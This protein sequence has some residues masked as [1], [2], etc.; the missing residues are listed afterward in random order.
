MAL[1]V[2]LVDV[3][4]W[5]DKDLPA[6]FL[7]GFRAVGVIADTGVHRPLQPPPLGDMSDFR[8]HYDTVIMSAGSTRRTGP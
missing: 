6:G 7:H 1:L 2:L 3:L 4:E 5:P 8:A